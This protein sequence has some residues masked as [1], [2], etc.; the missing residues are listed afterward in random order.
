MTHGSYVVWFHHCHL[1]LWS[2]QSMYVWLKNQFLL[3]SWGYLYQKLRTYVSKNLI[4]IGMEPVCGFPIFFHWEQFITKWFK[5]ALLE[6]Q[7]LC[8][9][10][11]PLKSNFSGMWHMPFHHVL[12]VVKGNVTMPL[13]WLLKWN[14]TNAIP[15]CNGYSCREYDNAMF[16]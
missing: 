12:V 11:L 1:R 4:D 8:H 10:T 14:G 5:Q 9:Y 2:F 16:F 13:S 7:V 15:P 6:Y 3:M